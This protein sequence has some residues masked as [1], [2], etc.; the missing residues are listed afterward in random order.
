MNKN[1]F[2]K[3]SYFRHIF[4]AQN[5]ISSLLN[6]KISK[7]GH[8]KLTSNGFERKSSFSYFHS[9]STLPKHLALIFDINK[10]LIMSD[11]SGKKDINSVLNEILSEIAYG[12]QSTFL[13]IS[14]YIFSLKFLN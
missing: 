5:R 7:F 2:I 8:E 9:D 13:F 6:H 10:T 1:L 4:K 12:N 11:L 14:V 3:W